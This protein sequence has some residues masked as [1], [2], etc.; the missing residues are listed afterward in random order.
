MHPRQPRAQRLHLGGGGGSARDEIDAGDSVLHPSVCVG[1]VHATRDCEKLIVAVTDDGR[2]AC[3][4]LALRCLQCR[5]EATPH[6]GVYVRLSSGQY[7]LFARKNEP[8]WPERGARNGGAAAHT[9]GPLVPAPPCTPVC[10][11]V[12]PT[13][14]PLFVKVPVTVKLPITFICG[15]VTS[16]VEAAETVTLPRETTEIPSVENLTYCVGTPFSKPP[17]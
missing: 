9:G 14:C 2:V 3:R 4:E 16:T 13:A 6:R 15:T 11:C 7:V 10:K 12:L 5:I 17:I 1:G 8:V